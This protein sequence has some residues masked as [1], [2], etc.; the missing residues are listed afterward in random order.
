MKIKIRKFKSIESLDL[1]FDTN[2]TIVGGNGGGK[3][4]VQAIQFLTSCAQSIKYHDINQNSGGNTRGQK[5]PITPDQLLYAPSKE[6]TSL[7]DFRKNESE[8]AIDENIVKFSKGRNRAITADLTE[9]NLDL[10]GNLEVPFSVFVSGL[11]GVS[12]TETEYSYGYLK[13]AILYGDSNRFF[14]NIIL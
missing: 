13:K 5:Y 10:I 11:A 7:L 3:T 14:R 1:E 2:L 6:L 4:S 9:C 8:I 12:N